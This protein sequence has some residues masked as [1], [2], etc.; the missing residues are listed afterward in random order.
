MIEFIDLPDEILSPI[1]QQKELTG[2]LTIQY[3]N[4]TKQIKIVIKDKNGK[5]NFEQLY[6]QIDMIASY[7]NID[8]D[9]QKVDFNI[10]EIQSSTIMIISFFKNEK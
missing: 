4:S 10:E 3:N 7:F 1:V 2:H 9:P 5:L 8:Y 6:L